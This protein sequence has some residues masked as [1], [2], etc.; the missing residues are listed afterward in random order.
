M[1]GWYTAQGQYFYNLHI[2]MYSILL[3]LDGSKSS[4]L[5]ERESE[6]EREKSEFV[7]VETFQVF[8]IH[9]KPN[10]DK[11]RVENVHINWNRQIAT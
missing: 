8:C 4:T 5:K 10:Q 6:R 2:F 11:K 7:N 1:R 9:L 3:W